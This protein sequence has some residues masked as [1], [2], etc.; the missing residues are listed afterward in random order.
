MSLSESMNGKMIALFQFIQD[1]HKPAMFLCLLQE[2]HFTH[3][4]IK[5]DVMTIDA[6]KE[7]YSSWLFFS[8]TNSQRIQSQSI[9]NSHYKNPWIRRLHEPT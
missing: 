2:F 6:L 3:S 7:L 4:L 8:S 9:A 5:A 1:V